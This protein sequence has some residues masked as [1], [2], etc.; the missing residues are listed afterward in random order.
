MEWLPD[1][2]IWSIYMVNMLTVIVLKEV[3]WTHY[4]VF[5]IYPASGHTETSSTNNLYAS[6][7]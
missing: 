3:F 1:Q 5:Y 6:Q 4:A 7:E 2:S